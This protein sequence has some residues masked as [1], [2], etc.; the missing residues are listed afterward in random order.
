M[1]PSMRVCEI[2][3]DEMVRTLG[4]PDMSGM[5]TPEIIKQTGKQSGEKSTGFSWPIQVNDGPRSRQQSTYWFH[6]CGKFCDKNCD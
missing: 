4:G 3:N 2:M 6:N 1:Q 5:A